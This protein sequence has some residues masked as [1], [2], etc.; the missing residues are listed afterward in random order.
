MCF[1]L[2]LKAHQWLFENIFEFMERFFLEY[3]AQIGFSY[4]VFFRNA[5]RIPLNNKQQETLAHT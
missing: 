3:Y 1:I 4:R 5:H 2:S